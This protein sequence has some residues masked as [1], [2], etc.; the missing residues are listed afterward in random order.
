MYFNQ[1]DLSRSKK[2]KKP[3]KEILALEKLLLEVLIETKGLPPNF[4][5]DVFGKIIYIVEQDR[6]DMID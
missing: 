6:S 1:F 3:L 2:H 5:Y 4:K